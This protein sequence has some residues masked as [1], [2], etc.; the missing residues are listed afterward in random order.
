MS[1]A[2]VIRCRKYPDCNGEIGFADER[3]P[4]CHTAH[5]YPNVRA[6]ERE[7]P[8]LQERYEHAI[9][10]ARKRGCADL[11][12][13]FARFSARTSAVINMDHDRVYDLVSDRK[14]T[15]VGYWRLIEAGVRDRAKEEHHRSRGAVDNA[16]FTGYGK[17][18]TFAALT[19]SDSGLTNYGDCG[20]ILNEIA[21]SDRATILEENSHRFYDEFS[22]KWGNMP[23]GYRSVWAERHKVCVD[24]RADRINNSVPA[25][26][27][28]G[29]ILSLAENRKDDR[30]VEVHI[31]GPVK[32]QAFD[33]II[34]QAPPRDEH[35]KLTRMR[36]VDRFW[37]ITKVGY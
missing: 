19:A 1:D 3:C 20:V 32:A 17:N 25:D 37:G 5:S 22:D 14:N 18:M 9:T 34:F 12:Q 33:R 6:A 15:Y 24:K 8:H 21:I 10:D 11:V 2:G 29:L 23:Q 28:D 4:V 36:I 35:E 26:A 13:K 31:Y 16:L 30:F 7:S 27:F